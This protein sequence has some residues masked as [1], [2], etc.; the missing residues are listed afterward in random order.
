[1]DFIPEVRMDFIPSDDEELVG[2]DDVGDSGSPD[3][4]P[5]VSDPVIETERIQPEKSE[6]EPELE[7]SEPLVVVKKK[8][9]NIDVND[10]FE[11]HGPPVRLTKKGKPYKKRA[12]MSEETKEKLKLARVLAS[13]SRKKGFEDRKE[14]KALDKKEKELTHKVRVKRVKELE[15]EVDAPTVPRPTAPT[16][17]TAPIDIEKAIFEGINKYEILRKQRKKEKK[18][19]EAKEAEDNKIRETLMR[20][21]APKQKAYN[22]YKNCY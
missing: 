10:I 8:A 22:P 1:M 14:S 18:I 15:E 12:P 6:P 11:G 19:V 21:V 16:P 20:A 4:P 3:S 9:D 2:V 5:P 7:K 13:E 17:P